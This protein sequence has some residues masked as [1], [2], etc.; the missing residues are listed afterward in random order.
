MSKFP[1]VKEQMDLIQR[2]TTEIISEEKLV[3]RLE[4][5]IYEDKPLIVKL[6]CDPSRPDLHIGLSLIHICRCRRYSLCRSR[7]SPYH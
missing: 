2:G 5:S 6:G 4:N 7:W 1:P 3:N